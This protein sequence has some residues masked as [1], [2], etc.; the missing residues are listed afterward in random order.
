MKPV[1]VTLYSM[2]RHPAS[3]FFVDPV[4]QPAAYLKA[5]SRSS[6]AFWQA[7]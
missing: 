4:K 2:N 1:I 5:R 7:R 6:P 3:R